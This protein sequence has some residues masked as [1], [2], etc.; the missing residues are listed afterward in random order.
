M[1]PLFQS[2]NKW[3]EAAAED[4]EQAVNVNITKEMSMEEVVNNIL[5]MVEDQ[6]VCP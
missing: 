2:V 6:T 4:E 3:S 1:K 5:V